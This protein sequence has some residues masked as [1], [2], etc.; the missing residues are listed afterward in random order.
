M[1]VT[2]QAADASQVVMVP[3]INDSLVEGVERFTAQLSVPSGQNRVMLG[4]NSAT[5][6]ITDDDSE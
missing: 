1:P 6:E 2:I 4:S 3:I 5:V